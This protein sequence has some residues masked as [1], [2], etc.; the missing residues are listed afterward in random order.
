VDWA[1]TKPEQSL[2]NLMQ[3]ENLEKSIHKSLQ[4][5]Q[6]DWESVDACKVHVHFA[7]QTLLLK[8]SRFKHQALA[9]DG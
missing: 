4:R 2:L 8:L 3:T 9:M 7:R 5:L 1:A 6:P